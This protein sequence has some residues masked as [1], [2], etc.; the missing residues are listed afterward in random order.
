MS[1]NKEID[2][3]IEERDKLITKKDGKY[4]STDLK[5][6]YTPV[7]DFIGQ[8]FEGYEPMNAEEKNKKTAIGEFFASAYV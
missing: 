4:V 7:E 2:K 1:N 5:T 8:F 3:Y 6:T